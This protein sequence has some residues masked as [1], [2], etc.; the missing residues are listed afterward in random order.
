MAGGRWNPKGVPVLYTCATASTA[1][2][3]V[4]VHVSGMIPLRNLYLVT[5]EV[6]DEWIASAYIPTLPDDWNVLDRDPASTVRIARQW[7]A[8]GQQLVMRV[9]SVV[10][11]A[12]SNLIL[13]TAHPEM[14]NVS[15]IGKSSFEMDRRLFL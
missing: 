7:L 11:P 13:N 10:C 14:R 4:R 8:A 12:D 9:P 6:P 3:E 1:V 2:L 15:V 5:L